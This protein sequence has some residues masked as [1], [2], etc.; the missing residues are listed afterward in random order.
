LRFIPVK[1]RSKSALK[2]TIAL[3]EEYREDDRAIYT[4]AI[5]GLEQRLVIARKAKTLANK[6]A[7]K[8][9]R[10]MLDSLK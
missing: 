3:I 4:G 1:D 6:R 8:A 7:E 2:T 5:K 9:M 10:F